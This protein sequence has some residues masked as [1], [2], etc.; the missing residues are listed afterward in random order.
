MFRDESDPT[1]EQV[2][3]SFLPLLIS[4][5]LRVFLWS[6]HGLP[7]LVNANAVT[8]LNEEQTIKYYRGY[9]AG[10]LPSAIA[11]RKNKIMI[12]IGCTNTTSI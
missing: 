6:K 8:A 7:P 10:D 12:A 2:S 11:H 1:S 4:V 9:Y 5:M 3:P